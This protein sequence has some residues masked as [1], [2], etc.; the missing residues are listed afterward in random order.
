MESGNGGY[1]AGAIAARLGGAA[2]IT[3]RRPIPLDTP[4]ETREEGDS[5]EVL[6]GDRLIAEGERAPDFELAVPAPPTLGDARQAA[7]RYRGL[8][9]GPFCRCFVCGRAREDGMGVF[10]GAVEGRS[11]VASPWTP[12]GWAADGDGVVQPQ[13]VWAALDCPTYFAA[14]M[15]DELA[16]SFLARMT[17]RV[18]VPVK[19]EEQMVIAWPLASE[20]R[21]RRAGSAVL[22]PDGETL[23]VAEA[24]LI[25]PRS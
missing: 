8:S 19:A 18:Q 25:E 10:A 6:D 24:L 1:A 14:Y 16:P 20:G 17:A 13:I 7:A 12:P 23:A 15:R 22:S 5:L 11:L 4:L 21:K 3:L 2:E 9:D